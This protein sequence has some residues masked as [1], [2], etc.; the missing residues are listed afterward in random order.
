MAYRLSKIFP[1]LII[2]VGLFIAAFVYVRGEIEFNIRAQEHFERS[3]LRLKTEITDRLLKYQYGLRGQRGFIMGSGKE[4]LNREFFKSYIESRDIA[5]E[6]PGARAFGFIERVAADDVDS[7]LKEARKSVLP[8]FRITEIKTNNADRFVIKLAEPLQN[9]LPA[10]GFDIASEHSRKEAALRAIASGKTT[11]TAPIS[12]VQ[13]QGKNSLGALLLLPVYRNGL[14]TQTPAE[15]DL[16]TVGWVY[17]AIQVS[18]VFQDLDLE[19]NQLQ[20]T[21]SDIATNEEPLRLLTQGYDGTAISWKLLHTENLEFFGRTW[22]LKVGASES[23]YAASRTVTI[24]MIPSGI[25]ALSIL[26]AWLTRLYILKTNDDLTSAQQKSRLAVIVSSSTDAII[27]VSVEGYFTDWNDGAEHIFGYCA[28]DLINTQKTLGFLFGENSQEITNNILNA[29]KSNQVVERLNVT[30]YQRNGSIVHTSLT[31]APIHRK[32]GVVIGAAL[33]IRDI[34]DQVAQEAHILQLNAS[35]EGQVEERTKEIRAYSAFQDAIT[36]SAG[37]TIIATDTTGI[38]NLFNPA[39]EKLLGYTA[40]EMV[41]LMSPA[42]FHDSKEVEEHAKTLTKILNTEVQP[43]FDVFVIESRTGVPV[44]KEWSYIAKDGTRIP[45]LLTVSVLRDPDHHIFG[46]LVIAI[47]LSDS[48]KQEIALRNSERFLNTL[49]DNI[50]GMVGYWDKNLYCRFANIKYLEWFGKTKQEMLGIFMPDLLGEKLF[51]RNRSYV[52]GTLKGET[53]SFERA[54]VK[55][56]GSTGYTWAHYLPDVEDG[57]VKGFY[58]L[59]SDI[60]ELKAVQLELE[61]TNETLRT[62]QEQLI[63]ASEVAELG[64]WSWDINKNIH[65]WNPKMYE[66][67]ELAPAQ[68]DEQ[69]QHASWRK[70]IH[71][72]DVAA[73]EAALERTLTENTSFQYVFRIITPRQGIRYIQAAGSADHAEN[74]TPIRMTGINRDITAQRD[75]ECELQEARAHAEEA[76]R[77]KSQFVANM[78]HEIRTPM[79]AVLGM[80]ELVCR[81]DL[82]PEQRK[83]MEMISASGQA[84]MSIIN[85]ILD[86]SKIE[87][88]RMELASSEFDL[89]NI[90]NT[91]ATMMTVNQAKQEREL[92]I[93][94]DEDVPKN[95]F[96]DGLRLQQILVNLVGN[97]LKFTAQGE[98]GIFVKCQAKETDTVLLSFT[99]SDTGIGMS[100]EQQT[101]LFQPFSQADSSMARRFG[102][103]GLGLSISLALVKLMGGDL[104]IESEEGKGSKFTVT[105]QFTYNPDI[106]RDRRSKNL[107]DIQSVL[108]VEANENSRAYIQK[109]VKYWGWASHAFASDLE[110]IAHIQH[111]DKNYDVVLVARSSNDG[112]FL[113]SAIFEAIGQTPYVVL[114]NPY[115]RDEIR[116]FYKKNLLVKPIT[117]SSLFNAIHEA[118]ISSG[119]LAA[120]E[121]SVLTKKYVENFQALA[122]IKI[123]LAEDNSLNQIVARGILD[124][125]GVQ[126]DIVNNGQ[127]AVDI[128]SSNSDAYD[129]VLMDIQ[130]P[131]MDGFTATQIIRNDLQLQ[132]PIIAMTAGVMASEQSQCIAFGMNDFIAKPVNAEHMLKVIKKQLSASKRIEQDQ[133]ST[134]NEIVDLTQSPPPNHLAGKSYF[135]PSH[136]LATATNNADYRRAIVSMV[137]KTVLQDLAPIDLAFKHWQEKDLKSAARIF[138]SLRGSIG[139]L[140]AEIIVERSH[141]IEQ[142]I[143]SNDALSVEALFPIMREDMRLTLKAMRAWREQELTELN[144]TAS[145][146]ELDTKEIEAFKNM[147]LN[148]NLDACDCYTRLRPALALHIKPDLIKQLDQHMGQLDFDQALKVISSQSSAF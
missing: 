18:T 43:G 114:T 146:I 109:L 85:D 104:L 80:T 132:L 88:G 17:C 59:V 139:T 68:G 35:L 111:N 97:A 36:R 57:T 125:W 107:G 10:I 134:P 102:G 69:V 56:D 8:D 19:N 91:L 112:D 147:L 143:L 135:N 46:Y 127:E 25:L 79:N 52:E 27:A 61:R 29:I 62:A 3:T 113:S 96:G 116:R 15:R 49:T 7:F 48:R 118:L 140:G 16:A 22:E 74:G 38:I 92:I 12:L 5:Q 33:T 84:L 133:L 130:M 42:L 98:V 123:L 77:A 71:P 47:D 124:Q 129:L 94:I 58:V 65:H 44:A 41:G 6:F 73:V 28:A 31:A 24:W 103:T 100:G 30:A 4:R 67:Y 66:I 117:S 137:E 126:L 51:E 119:Q 90:L 21:I 95:L 45:V 141:E 105:V 106:E 20:L 89:D 14:A 54:L 110:A 75:F 120:Y 145:P 60:T 40:K 83:Y 148:R 26:M 136:L 63:K 86:F 70:R 122:G 82:A 87:A 76:S 32:D 99:V 2:V 37:L 115:S 72:D 121:N 13:A 138:H 101:R 108:I 144:E 53:F 93:G 64:V 1:L 131:E 9:N 23:F 128:L 34:S 50:P 78:S 39:A 81:G 142:A 11:M 55:A